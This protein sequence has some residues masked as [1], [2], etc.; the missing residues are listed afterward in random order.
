MREGTQTYNIAGRRKVDEPEVTCSVG[1]VAKQFLGEQVEP[2]QAVYGAVI[3]VWNEL[4]PAELAEHCRIADITGGQIT[5][6]VDSPS[7]RYELNLCSMD[8]LKEL[9]TQ[10]PGSRLKKIKFSIP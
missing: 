10:F 7:Y 6:A 4:L 8:I 1:Q 9:Q 2:K 3:E 5:V